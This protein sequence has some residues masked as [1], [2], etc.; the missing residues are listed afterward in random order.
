MSNVWWRRPFLALARHVIAQPCPRA[1][2]GS[3]TL[4]DALSRLYDDALARPD[5]R[6]EHGFVKPPVRGVIAFMIKDDL[7][8]IRNARG[9]MKSLHSY[10]MR[11]YI[12]AAR[13]QLRPPGATR[14][15]AR[16][17]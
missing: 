7:I 17:P 13:A 4:F 14:R 12:R 5:L 10:S 1:R 15:S 11:A 3:A 6:R 16:R 9:R 8:V 2:V